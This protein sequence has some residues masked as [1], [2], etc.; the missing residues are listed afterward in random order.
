MQCEN[1]G[2]R[3]AAIHLTQ[4]V[5]NSVT[6]LHLCEV[7]AEEK[8]VKTDATLNKYPLSDL[9]ASMG[10]GASAAVPTADE[11]LRCPACHASLQDFRDSGRL[12]CPACYDTFQRHLRD[13]LRRVH[14]SSHHVGEQYQSLVVEAPEAPDATLEELRDKLRRAVEAEQFELAAE[15]RDRIRGIE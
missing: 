11:G 1:C 4:I 6:T 8:G 7:C 3:A 10:K 5:N 12:G 13:L 14:G 9:L 15:L 2:E